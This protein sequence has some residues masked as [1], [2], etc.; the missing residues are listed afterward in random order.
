[1]GITKYKNNIQISK[2][3][4]SS[5]F[6]CP[7]CGEVII[8]NE[9]INKL[10]QIFNYV[11][12]SKCIISSGYRCPTYDKK[13]NGFVGKHGVGLA[14]DCA[15]Y[16]NVNNVIS[17]KIICCLAYELK[18]TGIA[19]IDENY[20]HLDIRNEG[21][22]Y[23]DERKG[24]SSYWVNPYTYFNVNPNDISK[25]LNGA[26]KKNEI[27]YQVHGLGKNWYSN[28]CKG[29]NDYAGVFG[30]PID[31][32][33]IDN[34]EYR[35]RLKNKWLSSVHGRIDYAGIF[36]NEITALA[37]KGASY[38]VH[39]KNGYWLPWVDGYNINDFNNGYAGNGMVI[40]AIQIR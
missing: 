4:N 24:N 19:Y 26:S 11:N 15:F 16:D 37:I 29:T 35:V 9:L 18:F 12:A 1:M 28:V 33:Y 14:C 5:E 30:I 8:S 20:V 39:I 13:E 21:K 23:G 3:F 38:R 22:Y 40:D 7:H 27:K 31:A 6:K 32:V 36:G 2:H 25:Y 17:S 34:L 10:E